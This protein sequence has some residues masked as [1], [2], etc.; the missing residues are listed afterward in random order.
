MK[1][2]ADNDCDDFLFGLQSLLMWVCG[3]KWR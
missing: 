3:W 1:L 2:S